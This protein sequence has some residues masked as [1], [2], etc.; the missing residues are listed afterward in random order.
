MAP[1]GVEVWLLAPLLG[2]LVIGIVTLLKA[3]FAVK[4]SV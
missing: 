3:E 1:V 2:K 4:D